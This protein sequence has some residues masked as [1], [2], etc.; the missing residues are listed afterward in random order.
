M[1]DI[2]YVCLKWCGELD[3]R[4][5]HDLKVPLCHYCSDEPNNQYYLLTDA[6]LECK[7][8]TVSAIRHSLA[9]ATLFR[10]GWI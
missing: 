4:E 8:R 5:L 9:L 7:F 10:Q 1:G 2:P 3:Q 6:T